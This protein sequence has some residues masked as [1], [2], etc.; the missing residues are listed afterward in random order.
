MRLFVSRS[1]LLDGHGRLVGRGR[2][3]W[4]RW[5]WRRRRSNNRSYTVLG[6]DDEVPIASAEQLRVAGTAL[7]A[8]KVLRLVGPARA[9]VAAE[10]LAAVLEPGQGEA[11]GLAVLD[12]QLGRHEVGLG[13][14]QGVDLEGAVEGVEVL[15]TAN[16]LI[17]LVPVSEAIKRLALGELE[18][19]LDIEG[20]S[21]I[22][23]ASRL[24][25]ANTRDVA[26]LVQGRHVLALQG[27]AAVALPAVLEA[28]QLE[29]AG[30]TGV[31]AAVDGQVVLVDAAAE[32]EGADSVDSVSEASTIGRFPRRVCGRRRRRPWSRLLLDR[33]F[34]RWHVPYGGR[35][36]QRGRGARQHE[37]GGDGLS[38]LSFDEDSYVYSARSE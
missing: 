17:P 14:A 38:H 8:V 22:T 15:V 4:R 3:W 35:D 19:V 18:L 27:V 32:V 23:T 16:G 1:V 7:V 6:V 31:E 5:W 34:L 25:V 13:A 24:V 11:A 26:S 21:A 36:A 9:V 10:A 28:G 20:Q 30:G 2:R 37:D 29:A 33:G 12:A